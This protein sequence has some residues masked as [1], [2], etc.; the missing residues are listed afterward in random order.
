MKNILLFPDRALAKLAIFLIRVYQKTVSPDHSDFP[1]PPFVGCKFWPSCS[2]F[3]AQTFDKKGFLL[4]VFP[5]VF[6]LLRC[7]P[8]AKNKIDLPK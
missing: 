2:E 7:H 6:R 8:F 4:G 3:A 5:V 1:H